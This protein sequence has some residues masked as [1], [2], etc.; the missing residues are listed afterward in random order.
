MGGEREIESLSGNAKNLEV[1]TERCCHSSPL[2]YCVPVRALLGSTQNSW[3]Q[4]KSIQ[5]NWS[6]FDSECKLLN[7][8]CVILFNCE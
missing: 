6:C 2:T 1:I 8:K 4:I 5:T 7:V 3:W